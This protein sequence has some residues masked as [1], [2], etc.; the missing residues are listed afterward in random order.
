M[1]SYKRM[2]DKVTE[3]EITNI[4]GEKEIQTHTRG[5]IQRQSDLALIP[6]TEA[7][8]DYLK[9]LED[10]KNGAKV[11]DFDYEAEAIKVAEDEAI[12]ASTKYQRDRAKE[13]PTTDELIVALWED[14]VE[15]RPESKLALQVKRLE[16][17]KKYSK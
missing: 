3:T 8:P 13:Y 7:N 10:V 17:K 12:F 6:M 14:V 2:K 1:E 9:Y 5:Y 15:G 4:N 11:T 16:I